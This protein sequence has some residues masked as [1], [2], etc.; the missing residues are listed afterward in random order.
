MAIWQIVTEKQLGTE[1]WVNDWY[2]SAPDQLTAQ[3]YAGDIID[4]EAAAY[5]D[6]ITIT[7]FRVRAADTPGA[8]GTVFA[9][10]VQ[11]ERAVQAYLPLFNVVRLDMA[12]TTGRPGRKYMKMPLAE[13]WQ[14]NG[15]LT[16]GYLADVNGTTAAALLGL[17]VLT[18]ADGDVIQS[19][20]ASPIVGMRQL[21][22][23]SRKRTQPII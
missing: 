9:V 7:K 8:Q 5:M 21:R 23:G 20:A 10:G 12:V 11:G 19:I 4:I 16:T 18:Q 14:E 1:I 22:R 6:V 2:V 13:S 15:V 3:G 17:G